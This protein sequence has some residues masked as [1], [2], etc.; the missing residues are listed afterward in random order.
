MSNYWQGFF[1]CLM[2]V[3]II[4]SF[5]MIILFIRLFKEDGK[6]KAQG[7]GNE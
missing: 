6:Q 4:N 1:N 2:W 7:C 5:G 3:V